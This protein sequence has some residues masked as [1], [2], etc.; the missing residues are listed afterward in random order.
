LSSWVTGD[1]WFWHKMGHSIVV[2]TNEGWKSDGTNI[3]GAGIAKQASEKF[4][5]L[6]LEYGRLCQK[7]CSHV[8]L[9]N[10][11]LVLVPTKPLVSAKPFLS[12]KQDADYKVVE[13][14]LYWIQEHI[15]D[16]K[17][18]KLYVPILGA[19]C[20][21]LEKREIENMMNKIL[22]SDRIIKVNY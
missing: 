14:S 22:L 3:M 7:K 2:P 6:P 16:V 21:K 8:I 15:S 5:N 18:P 1:I 9:D 11:H 12:W 19:G 20:G 10:Y 17:T 4:P 13:N